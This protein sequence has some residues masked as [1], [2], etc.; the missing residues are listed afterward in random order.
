MGGP[1]QLSRSINSVGASSPWHLT[2]VADLIAPHAEQLDADALAVV[3]KASVTHPGRWRSVLRNV[4]QQ[5]PVSYDGITAA[6]LLE[7]IGDRSD[8]RRLRSFAK[9]RRRTPGAAALGRDLARRTA[10]RVYVEDQNRVTIHVG[11]RQVA[12]STI[13][14][15]VLAL[16][17]LLLTRSD[18]SSTR[19]QV[20]DAL[21][22]DLNPADA[23]N[24]LNQ[25]VY[26]LRRVFEEDYVEDLS[27]GYVH[28]DSDVIWLDAGL[29]MSRSNACRTLIRNLPS[30]P[31]PDDVQRLEDMYE[32]RFALDF[33]YE[34]WAAP[35]RDWLHASFLE[36]IERAVGRDLETGHHQRGIRLARRALDV[37]PMA[38]QVEVS[39]LRL[40]RA[41][42]AHAAAAEQYGHY[43]ASIREQL[44]VEPPPLE[45]L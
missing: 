14:R 1:T 18:F 30:E 33:E 4:I 23:V 44:G 11:E 25:T 39:L 45:S 34:E 26:F 13:R 29:V 37:D 12:G 17:C 8:V 24:S 27:P 7:L 20:L 16:L 31:S 28:H 22:P 36:I 3:A 15:K 19:D 41:S 10:D 6:R 9:A 35:Y 5:S 2:L 43:A 40:Y 38:E 32:G 21:W 42:G